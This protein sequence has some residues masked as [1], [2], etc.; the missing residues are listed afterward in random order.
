[1]EQRSPGGM[2]VG[3]LIHEFLRHGVTRCRDRVALDGDQ[4]SPAY[5]SLWGRV[6]YLAEAFR[7]YRVV[8]GDR[9]VALINNSVEWAELDRA[10]SIAGRIPGRPMPFFEMAIVD[11]KGLASYK[12]PVAHDVLERIPL[13]GAA[14]P[15][16]RELR[17]PYWADLERR[18][19]G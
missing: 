7:T 15:L 17:N 1:M 6:S 11:D 2:D 13:R 19:N 5:S 16:H 8:K 10:T 4:R 3:A 14:K 12:K 9:V 18:V